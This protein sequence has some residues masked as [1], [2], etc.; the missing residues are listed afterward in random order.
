MNTTE[1][2]L[3]PS[4]EQDSTHAQRLV[5]ELLI[6]LQAVKA[7][8]ARPDASSASPSPHWGEEKEDPQRHEHAAP[9][10]RP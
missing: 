5:D 8:T 9:K 10:S 4:T 3:S 7:Q 2:S 6:A 1:Y